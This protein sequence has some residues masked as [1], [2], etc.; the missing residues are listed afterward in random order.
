[1]AL[2]DDQQPV[3]DLPAQVPII[4]SHIA[5][6]LGA[7]GQHRQAAQQ[8]ADKQ[9]DDRDDH[10]A[11]IPARQPAQAR[12]SNRAPQDW[13]AAASLPVTALGGPAVLHPEPGLVGTVSGCMGF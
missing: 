4:L 7:P 1:V 6:I 13:I 9:V 10:S 12:S 11:M 5:F 3:E 8:T 2:V